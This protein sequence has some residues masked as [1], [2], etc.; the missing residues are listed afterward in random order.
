MPLGFFRPLFLVFRP[1]F[2][3]PRFRLRVECFKVP[4]ISVC[5]EGPCGIR[6]R[7]FLRSNVFPLSP[8]RAI[9]A[10][11]SGILSFFAQAVPAFSLVGDLRARS[12]KFHNE[13]FLFFWEWI[14]L[15]IQTPPP[16][17]PPTWGGRFFLWILRHSLGLSLA[18][19][20]LSSFLG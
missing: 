15:F 14:F 8:C 9:F 19:A 12:G 13:L 20:P 5:A 16:R 10:V 6:S 3:C 17:L 1:F 18:R 4:R 11:I 7:E 2:W